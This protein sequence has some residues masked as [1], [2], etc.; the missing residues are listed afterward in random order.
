MK[1]YYCKANFTTIQ[2]IYDHTRDLCHTRISRREVGYRCSEC[3][4]LYADC[5]GWRRH[6]LNRH[7]D[8]PGTPARARA[9]ELSEGSALTSP[10]R[11]S[12]CEVTPHRDSFSASFPSSTPGTSRQLFSPASVAVDQVQHPECPPTPDAV[13]RIAAPDAHSVEYMTTLFA[14]V[15][16]CL[17]ADSGVTTSLVQQFADLLSMILTDGF[18]RA[19]ESTIMSNL[20][21]NGE[22]CP[23]LVDGFA[24]LKQVFRGGFK[25]FLTAHLREKYFRNLGTYIEP[26]CVTLG[27]QITAT[28]R[29]PPRSRP[30]L[31]S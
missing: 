17:H 16:S 15:F 7:P 14:R 5:Y 30:P 26:I 6:L 3:L 9:V 13:T 29:N 27:P 22:V 25:H 8:L 20:R 10:Y 23:H 19:M 21:S 4:S 11:C 18:E 28:G 24:H 31:P 1:C 12:P 2:D